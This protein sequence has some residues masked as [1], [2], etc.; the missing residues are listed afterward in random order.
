[1][2]QSLTSSP[3][4]RVVLVTGASSGIGYATCLHFAKQGWFVAGTARSAE[5][6]DALQHE[7]NAA[8][9]TDSA[10]L[11]I[12]ADVREADAMHSAVDQVMSTFGRLDVLVANAGVGHRGAAADADWDHLDTLLRTNI[13][14]VLHSIR[15][16]VPAM[17]KNGAGQI[18]IV[19]SVVWNM[20]SP[21]AALYAASKA[22]VSSLARSLRFELQ[23]DHIAVTDLRIGRVQ[24]G[25]N[26]NRLGMSGRSKSASFLPEMAPEQVAAAIFDAVRTRQPIVT[27]RWL[28]RLLILANRLF[29]NQIGQRASRQYKPD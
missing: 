5:K 14:G 10:F 3:P 13:D 27:V 4:A 29:P 21:Y 2:I 16:A 26:D 6:L 15:A 12:V 19:S 24:T 18:I 25:F 9:N 23:P 7:I 8:A 20:V 22:F 1:M 28:D 11:P 17:R